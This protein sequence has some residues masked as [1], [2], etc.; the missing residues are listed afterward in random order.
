MTRPNGEDVAV[1]S[2]R[3]LLAPAIEVLF[4]SARSAEPP[5]SSG[6][7]VA[8][9]LMV[10]PD[11]FLVAIA[12]PDSKDGRTDSTSSGKSLAVRRS[13]SAAREGC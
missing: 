5:H 6:M 4:Y 9:A 11:A 12:A 10:S 8:S 13:S 7:T 3:K 1:S 2:G